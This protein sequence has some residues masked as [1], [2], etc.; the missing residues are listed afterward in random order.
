MT[1]RGDGVGVPGVLEAAGRRFLR[2]GYAATTVASIAD[3]AGVSVE[4]LYKA[5]G[6]K[7]GLV[8]GLWDTALA[9]EG[10]VHAE[11]RSD[12]V[13]G[14]EADPTVIIANWAT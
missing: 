13:A 11:I 14:A 6:G 4:L 1:A 10:P 5:F 9:G 12:T 8:R 7:P 2:D 3:D